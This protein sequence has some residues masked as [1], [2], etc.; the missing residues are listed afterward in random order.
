MVKQ[1]IYSTENYERIVKN[2]PQKLTYLSDLAVN[3]EEVRKRKFV[4]FPKVTEE[5][6]NARPWVGRLSKI[7]DEF[8]RQG[9]INDLIVHGSMGDE[10]FTNFSDIELTLY[11]K[12]RVFLNRKNKNQLRIS[13]KKL[14]KFIVEFDPLQ[15]HGPFF[16]W[17][18]LIQNYNEDILPI[19]AYEN[20]WSFAGETVCFS[21]GNTQR[22][23]SKTKVLRT[24][25][26]LQYPEVTFFRRGVNPF[27]AKRFLSNFFILPAFYYQSK[28]QMLS[29]PQALEKF[30]ENFCGD[31][32]KALA[33]SSEV[34]QQWGAPPKWL[35]NARAWCAGSKVPSGRIDYLLCFLYKDKKLETKM[36]E[37]VIPSVSKACHRI[38][39][40]VVDADF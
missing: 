8:F 36:R 35:G 6:A 26:K 20:A 4:D 32:R 21:V 38:R 34:R 15:H 27:T 9:L 3:G 22:C 24:L 19:S 12:Q 37:E 29:K 40:Q 33:I 17:P 2:W 31:V 39:K 10:T 5:Y 7:Y 14:N 23:A 30:A 1:V 13:L 25:K 11:L 16:L 28:G 18:D